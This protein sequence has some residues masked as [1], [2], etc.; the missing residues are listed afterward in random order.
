MTNTNCPKC[1]SSVV[2]P[3]VRIIDHGDNNQSLDLS[4]TVYSNPKAWVLK[5]AITQRFRA[6]VCGDCGYTEFY[7]ENPQTLLAAARQVES[8]A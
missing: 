1:G 5:G 3:N 8:E 6:R 7:V 4:A 2:I